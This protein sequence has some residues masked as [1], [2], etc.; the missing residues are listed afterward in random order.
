MEGAN[1]TTNWMVGCAEDLPL[2]VSDMMVKVHAHVIKH[3]SFGL[4]LG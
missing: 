4:L 2:Q 1:G 3:M